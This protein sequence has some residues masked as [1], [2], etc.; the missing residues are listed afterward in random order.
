MSIDRKIAYEELD[1]YED[2]IE[3]CYIEEETQKELDFALIANHDAI[4]NLVAAEAA[5]RAFHQGSD[6]ATD[7]AKETWE[8]EWYPYN[9]RKVKDVPSTLENEEYYSEFEGL[10]NK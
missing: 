5:L 9:D 6:R 3:C 10:G 4:N 1:L 7:Q 8:P 2:Y